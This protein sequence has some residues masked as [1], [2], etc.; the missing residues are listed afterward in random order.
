[1]LGGTAR[2]VKNYNVRETDKVSK[3]KYRK[4]L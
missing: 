1:M 2:N 3:V 4:I